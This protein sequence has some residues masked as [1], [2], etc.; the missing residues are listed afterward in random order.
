[1]ALARQ[2]YARL[3]ELWNSTTNGGQHRPAIPINHQIRLIE[4]I[5]ELPLELMNKV[6]AKEIREMEAGTAQI[7][8]AQQTILAREACI[9]QIVN[10]NQDIQN[11]QNNE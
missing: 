11:Q 1:M 2:H 6:M 3:T 4:A 10:L 5:R 7:Q 8:L 9:Q